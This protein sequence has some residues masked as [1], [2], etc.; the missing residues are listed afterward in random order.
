MAFTVTDLGDELVAESDDPR[1]R[2]V[3]WWWDGGPYA[4]YG[5]AGSEPVNVLNLWD[6]RTSAPRVAVTAEAFAEYLTAVY[7]DDDEVE[8]TVACIAHGP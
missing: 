5:L 8:A 2:G 3:V 4:D 6:Y 1:L 7:A